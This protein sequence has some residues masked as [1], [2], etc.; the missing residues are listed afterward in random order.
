MPE[1]AN[2][3][4]IDLLRPAR[5]GHAFDLLI[6]TRGR[7]KQA[8]TARRVPHRWFLSP[9]ARF[10]FSDRRPRAR[11]AH[12]VDRLITLVEVAAGRA[13]ERDVRIEAPP[14]ARERAATVLGEGKF[15]SGWVCVG[16]APG[17]GH[18]KKRWPLERFIEI[19]RQQRAR[20]RSPVFVLGPAEHGVVAELRAAV[21]LAAF[22][23]QSETYQRLGGASVYDTIALG[24]RMLASVAND[25][26]VGHMLAASGRPLLS[27][28]GPTCAAKLRSLSPLVTAVETRDH[29]G[30]DDMRGLSEQ[31]VDEALET[32]MERASAPG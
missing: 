29:G 13:L 14:A 4:T 8:A 30:G 19:A 25:S 27:L 16:I 9:A 24:E 2:R 20:G 31:V 6:D 15:D 32:V 10:V 3:R 21:P 18:P 17:A 22:P 26:G 1:L 7:W 5:F 28:F 23:L 12:V 11:S